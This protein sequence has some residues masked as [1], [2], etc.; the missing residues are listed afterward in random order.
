MTRRTS[1]LT[2]GVL[3][4]GALSFRCADSGSGGDRTAPGANGPAAPN[5]SSDGG[6]EGTV[7][8]IDGGGTTLQEAG[9]HEVRDCTQLGAVGQWDAIT[10][11]GATNENGVTHVLVDPVHAG[12]IYAGTD[13]K[14]LFR[15]DDCGANWTMVNTGTKG[16]L[17]TSGILWSM[18]IDRVKPATLFA[19]SLYGSDLGLLR[20]TNGGVDW[21]SLWPA[22]SEIAATVEYGFLQEL[23][24]DPTDSAH[25]VVSFHSNCT[26]PFGPMCMAE[27]MDSGTSWRLFKG[28]TSTWG[29][30]ARPIV[31]NHTTWLYVTWGDGVF[32]T[33]DSGVTWERVA[34]GGNHQLYAAADGYRYLGSAFGV[35]RSMDGRQWSSVDGSP[36]IDGLIGDGVRIFGGVRN[37]GPGQ[38]PY[39]VASEA[40]G[41][42]WTPLAS[43]PMTSGPVWLQYDADHHTLYSANANGG[44]WRMVTR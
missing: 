8:P 27:S 36:Q 24:I 19:G 37:P 5:G 23:A 32:Y 38:Q 16:A 22:T 34:N 9:L 40:N 7:G 2:T 17:L 30:N 15:S 12:T 4:F 3:L 31:I 1:L 11:P 35:I 21:E 10:P 25:L 18:A 13:K 29:E 39:Y 6:S 41:M 33:Q 44:L 14:G 42:T 20:S 26:G 43:P 28:P